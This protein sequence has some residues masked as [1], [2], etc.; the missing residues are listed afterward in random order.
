MWLVRLR[1]GFGSLEERSH[2]EENNMRQRIGGLMGKSTQKR[3]PPPQVIVQAVDLTR[4]NV[5]I[6]GDCAYDVLSGLDRVG[7]TG[8]VV[9]S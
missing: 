1:E 3:I 6:G 7:A 5:A 4:G 9:L 2:C 8:S